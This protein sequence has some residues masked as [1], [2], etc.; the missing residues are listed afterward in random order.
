MD[1]RLKKLFKLE[2]L[3]ISNISKR[4]PFGTRD[5]FKACQ[6]GIIALGLEKFV[7]ADEIAINIFGKRIDYMFSLQ[8]KSHKVKNENK[9]KYCIT[10]LLN[11]I[12][13]CI[14][15][16]TLSQM[17]YFANRKKYFNGSPPEQ[18]KAGV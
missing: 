10:A 3:L 1:V 15:K 13:G 16:K 12:E 5:K 18:R 11:I 7:Y 4:P 2:P 6:D 8:W 9:G 17:I 14:E